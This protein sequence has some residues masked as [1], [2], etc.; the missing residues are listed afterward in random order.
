MRKVFPVIEDRIIKYRES[1]GLTQKHLAAAIGVSVR[2]IQN[3]EKDSRAVSVIDAIKMAEVFGVDFT[4]FSTGEARCD[5]CANDNVCIN[6]IVDLHTEV[7][8]NFSD[9]NTAYEINN[10]LLY[11]ERKSKDDFQ[12][13]KYFVK[14]MKEAL[15]TKDH[16]G[17][18]HSKSLPF[19][20]HTQKAG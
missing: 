6:P 1:K 2:T 11:I 16:G 13:I 12:K 9:H 20:D 4:W 14:G 15:S 7:V 17:D 19:D 5:N 18:T 10:D 3:Y 8:R